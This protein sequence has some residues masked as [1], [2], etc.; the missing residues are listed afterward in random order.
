[1]DATQ[2]V[3]A[4]T[5][6][7][8]YLASD[9]GLEILPVVNK[10]DLASAD[11]ARCRSEI[12]DIIG[13]PAEDCPAISAKTGQNVHDVLERIVTDIPAPQGDA[14]K[15]L[16][17]LIFDSSYDSYLGVVVVMRIFD[18]S[19]AAGERVK[20]MSTGAVYEVAE[21]GTLSPFGYT[22]QERLYAG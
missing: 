11:V 17:A 18:G 16:K 1:M 12:E 21:V 10:I 5:L 4:Q 20:L 19:I 6:A 22:K 3:E 2:G 15:P 13:I 14:D 7:N 9:T 8:A